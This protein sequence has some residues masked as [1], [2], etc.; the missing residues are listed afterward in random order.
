MCAAPIGR[1]LENSPGLRGGLWTQTAAMRLWG[2]PFL[3]S[4][5]KFSFIFNRGFGFMRGWYSI[6]N[7]H[8]TN[9]KRVC[10]VPG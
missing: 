1:L 4:Q 3:G 6:K 8:S 7:C 2:H 5:E 9:K 10:T